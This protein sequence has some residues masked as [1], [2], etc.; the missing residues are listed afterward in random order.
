MFFL[1]EIRD[2]IKDIYQ[3]YSVYFNVVFKFIFSLVIFLSM[4][5]AIGFDSRISSVPFCV[6][7]ALVGGFVPASILTLLAVVLTCI[8]LLKISYICT[9]IFALVYVILWLFILRY[10]S[11][12]NYVILASVVLLHLGAPY[13]LPVLMGMVA[14]PVAAIAIFGGTVLYY[15]LDIC[16]AVNNGDGNIN[17]DEILQLYR[18]IMK[19]FISNK[20]MYLYIVLLVVICLYVYFIRTRKFD[21]ASEVAAISGAIVNIVLFLI[22]SIIM[23]VDISILSLVIW[24]IAAGVIAYVAAAF[25]RVLDY[26]AIEN[27]QFEDDD[28]YYYVKAVPKMKVAAS[29]NK[30][31]NITR[32]SGEDSRKVRREQE[33]SIMDDEF[34]NEM[35]DDFDISELDNIDKF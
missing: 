5:S 10:A 28:Y 35:D 31:K 34:I 29:H 23:E 7:L 19:G 15:L 25:I 11:A 18:Y 14:L 33:V 9:V 24:S 12:Y 2:K 3:K 6:V 16:V 4:R 30:V 17:A 22:G 1:L 8:Q 26:L 21:Y 20:E 27:V 32:M 13:I